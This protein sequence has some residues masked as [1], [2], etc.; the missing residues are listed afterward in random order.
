[1]ARKLTDVIDL[2]LAEIPLIGD[3]H[4][5]KQKLKSIRS[6]SLYA[7]PE[8]QGDWWNCTARILNSE[9]GEEDQPW[10]VKIRQIFAG[11]DNSGS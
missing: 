2:I 7:A 10:T 1:V 6:S 3:W 11:D 8:V 5:L 4:G 9:I